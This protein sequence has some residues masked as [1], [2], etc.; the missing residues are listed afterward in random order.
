MAALAMDATVTTAME[1]ALVDAAVDV[2]RK[3]NPQ[4]YS[5]RCSGCFVT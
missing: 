2:V 3:K 4:R 5:S 1:D